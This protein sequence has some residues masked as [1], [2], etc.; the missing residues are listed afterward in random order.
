MDHQAAV[1]SGSR[2]RGRECP[3]PPQSTGMDIYRA[4]IERAAL[5]RPCRDH[6]CRYHFCA[7]N[8]RLA[9]IAAA[10]ATCAIRDSGFLPAFPMQV[11]FRKRVLFGRRLRAGILPLRAGN[12]RKRAWCALATHFDAGRG[13]FLC[14]ICANWHFVRAARRTNGNSSRRIFGTYD[15][16]VV[17]PISSEFRTPARI[18]RLPTRAHDRSKTKLSKN[19]HDG[20]DCR[21]ASQRKF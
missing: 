3:L 4:D 14:I 11:V 18:M 15:S 9:S 7:A 20:P 5:N 13:R 6:A 1:A 8:L 16:K 2:Q 12:A 21:R 19:P 17:P 10:T